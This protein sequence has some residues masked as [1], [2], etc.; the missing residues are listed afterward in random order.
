MSSHEIPA[1]SS[2]TVQKNP[3]ASCHCGKLEQLAYVSVES[4]LREN[5]C[6][7]YTHPIIQLLIYKCE[8]DE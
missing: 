6:V 7:S 4:I 5:F 1:G 8:A 2:Q 3:D